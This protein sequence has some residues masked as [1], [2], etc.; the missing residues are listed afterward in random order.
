VTPAVKVPGHGI[1]TRANRRLPLRKF[2]DSESAS[3]ASALNSDDPIR[4]DVD[5]DNSKKI[6]ARNVFTRKCLAALPNFKHKDHRQ[7]RW[8]TSITVMVMF[9]SGTRNALFQCHESTVTVPGQP[10]HFGGNLNKKREIQKSGQ[11]TRGF[12]T[13][14]FF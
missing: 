10:R 4:V 1:G 5:R 8:E 2:D 7:S 11:E 14:V 12:F 6:V 13:R 9:L 3:D